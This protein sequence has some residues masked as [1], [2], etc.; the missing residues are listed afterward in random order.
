MIKNHYQDVLDQMEAMGRDED[1]DEGDTD[2]N[3]DGEE[4]TQR[5]E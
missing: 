1:E 3:G 4:E 2:E 5:P